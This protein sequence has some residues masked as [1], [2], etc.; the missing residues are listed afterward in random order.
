MRQKCNLILKSCFLLNRWQT[1]SWSHYLQD[2]VDPAVSGKLYC[3]MYFGQHGNISLLWIFILQ[4]C[5]QKWKVN[6]TAERLAIFKSLWRPLYNFKDVTWYKPLQRQQSAV[7]ALFFL[8][9]IRCGRHRK[10]L[11]SQKTYLR[12]RP[13]VSVFIW[14]RNFFVADTASVHTYPMKTVTENAT[15][16]KRSPE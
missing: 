14:K 11:S 2:P 6:G 1:S 5:Q 3:H 4:C 8:D 7:S 10:Y 9:L 13:H 15:F 12:P 16:W